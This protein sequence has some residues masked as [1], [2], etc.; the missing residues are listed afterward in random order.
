MD[1]VD[2]EKKENSTENSASETS[3][4]TNK[5]EKYDT[6]TTPSYK[7]FKDSHELYMLL[8]PKKVR[9]AVLSKEDVFTSLKT[10]QNSVTQNILNV[11]KASDSMLAT[12]LV[13]A[14]T[15]MTTTA[16][17]SSVSSMTTAL[18]NKQDSVLKVA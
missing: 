16:S 11:T 15:T 4:L 7:P 3:T 8:L 9:L 13:S 1:E 5:T 17:T 2:Q 14:Y 6:S 18:A 12:S 10:K